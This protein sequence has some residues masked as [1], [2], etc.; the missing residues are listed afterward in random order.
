[1][2][3]GAGARNFP[4]ENWHELGHINFRISGYIFQEMVRNFNMQNY[5]YFDPFQTTVLQ[6][7]KQY[8]IVWSVTSVKIWYINNVTQLCWHYF[9]SVKATSISQSCA[10]ITLHIR[11]KFKHSI[12]GQL[13]THSY[14][15]VELSSPYGFALFENLVVRKR[16]GTQGD[17]ECVRRSGNTGEG[18]GRGVENQPRHNKNHTEISSTGWKAHAELL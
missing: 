3:W 1:M 12:S 7:S 9:R 11:E 17:L 5:I 10:L 2:V 15:Q 18:L 8:F 6:Y 13:P 4:F 14:E 16:E